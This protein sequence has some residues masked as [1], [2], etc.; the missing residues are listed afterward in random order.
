MGTTQATFAVDRGVEQDRKSRD[1]E[2]RDRK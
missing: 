2:A 1:R